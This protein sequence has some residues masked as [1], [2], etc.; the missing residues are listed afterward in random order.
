MKLLGLAIALFLPANARADAPGTDVIAFIHVNVLPMDRERVLRDQTVIVEVATIKAIGPELKPPAGARIIDGHKTAY[1]SPGLADMHIHSDTRNDLAMYL[2]SGVTTVLHMG[3]ARAGFVDTIVPEANGGKIPA[4]QV[5]TGFLVDGTTAYNAFVI[6]TPDEARAIV[7]LAKTNG[8]DFI[9]VYVGLT[10]DVY[11]ALAAEALKQN[12]PLVGHGVYAVRLD[13]QLA[14]GQAMVAHAEE[15]FYS[16]FTP[17]GVKEKDA[18]PSLSRIPEAVALVQRYKPAITADL[19][20]YGTITRLIGHPETLAPIMSRPEIAYLTP[21]DRMAWRKSDYFTKTVNLNA[22]FAFLQRF[23][24]ALADGGVELI[25]GTDAPTIPGLFPG[26]SSHDALDAL[27]T[28]GLSRFQALSTATRAPGAFIHRT[29]GGRR[30]GIVAPGYAADL[31]LSDSNPLDDLATL[32]TPIGV[33]AQ[34]R[35]RDAASL[36]KIR[37]DVRTSYEAIISPSKNAAAR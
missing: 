25:A 21:A 22:K 32:R 16:Y 11:E 2:A 14:A 13:R 33:M 23:V 1:L 37:E 8:Y 36:D 17:A 30:F 28:A 31:I 5:Y 3:G 9:K 18:P 27:E 7:G 10:P 20:T 24:K 29:K 4:P 6:K 15:F 35:W 19:L 34:G 26:R 12:I